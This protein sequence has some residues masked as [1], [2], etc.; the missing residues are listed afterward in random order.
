[1]HG[2]KTWEIRP[3]VYRKQVRR[4]TA[5]EEETGI[6]ISSEKFALWKEV[7]LR[8]AVVLRRLQDSKGT[9]VPN[10]PIILGFDYYAFRPY[11]EMKAIPGTPL[12]KV[13]LDKS[14][15]GLTDEKLV[16]E[17]VGWFHQLHLIHQAGI[18]HG[19][20]S[21]ANL[22]RD[23]ETGEIGFVD[24]GLA[25]GKFIR[26]SLLTELIGSPGYMPPEQMGRCWIY[27]QSDIF[28]LASVLYKGIMGTPPVRNANSGEE[29]TRLSE[30]SYGRL[31]KI[32][33]QCLSYKIQ[34][35]FSNAFDVFKALRRL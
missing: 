10:T 7:L 16:S 12:N 4:G 14:T 26:Q 15:F 27:P 32:V 11:I 29:A 17:A 23:S 19:D 30:E 13:F 1:M 3:G 25:A 31:A 21:P 28:A 6:E 20:I 33:N 18:V 2:F 9:L 8:E 24:F 34:D 35:R 5:D 22:I